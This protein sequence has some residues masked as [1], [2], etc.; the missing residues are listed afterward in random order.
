M[1]EFMEYLHKKRAKQVA[2]LQRKGKR[3]PSNR[4]VSLYMGSIRHLF[5]EAK[6]KYND[7]DRNIIQ[8]RK[9]LGREHYQQ[10]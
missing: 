2:E 1:M 10:S 6:K 5:N 3:I 8:S 7:Y 9:Q 4:M